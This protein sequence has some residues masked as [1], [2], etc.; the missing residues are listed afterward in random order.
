[1][2][3][4]GELRILRY[5]RSVDAPVNFRHRTGDVDG[6]GGNML[7]LYAHAESA[8]DVFF[9]SAD[10]H[11]REMFLKGF[12]VYL[13][14]VFTEQEREFLKGILA[15]KESP[16]Q[17]GRAL[18]VEH[19]AFLQGIQ[20]K[21]YKNV[22]PLAKLARL[23]G[24]SGAEAFTGTIYERLEQLN[25]GF[26]LNDIIPQNRRVQK[27]RARDRELKRILRKTN[28]EKLK[29]INKK[30]YET[31]RAEVLQKQKEYARAYPEK[32]KARSL[33][34]K[35]ANRER[36]L[37]RNRERW[38]EKK[39]ELNA[40]RREARRANPDKYKATRVAWERA[41]HEELLK[42]RRDYE[43]KNRKK[44]NERMQ[45]YRK[46]NPEKIRQATK[47]YYEKNRE[48]LIEK[49]RNRYAKKKAEREAKRLASIEE[50]SL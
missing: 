31:H 10:E 39:D 25:A 26:A 22:K 7:D 15:G 9:G 35:E 16:Y 42:K 34:Y 3:K 24:W 4:S 46:A 8:E 5:G 28:P 6:N 14:K 11:A 17:V 44:L 38:N 50:A 41:N 49:S 21:A 48:K 37:E 43:A 12:R 27:I 32:I 13:K 18:G 20:R 1:M 45:N 36:I 47:T 23:T 40:R 30:W 33:A 2:S 29:S 19:F